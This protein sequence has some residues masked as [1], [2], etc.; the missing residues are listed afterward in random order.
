MQVIFLCGSGYRH[1]KLIRLRTA[2]LKHLRVSMFVH[3]GNNFYAVSGS[4]IKLIRL[5]NAILPSTG[6]TVGT[7]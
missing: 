1:T 7:L 5:R 3:V 4:G 6:T 2:I